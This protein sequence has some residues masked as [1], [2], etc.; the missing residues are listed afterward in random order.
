[1]SPASAGAGTYQLTY[2]LDNDPCNDA[3]TIDIVV[4]NSATV[5]TQ[6]ELL[7]IDSAPITLTVNPT[8]GTWSGDGIT[9]PNAGTFDP[10]IA[11]VGTHQPTYSFTDVN[12]CGVVASPTITV[13]GLPVLLAPDTLDVCQTNDDLSLPDL[14]NVTASPGGGNFSWMG[15][16]TQPNGIFNSGAAGLGEGFYSIR[17]TSTRN[18]CV[19]TDSLIVAV[20]IPAPLTLD[21]PAEICIAEGT[22]T[23]NS[24]LAGG[25]WTGPNIDPTTGEIDLVGA[26]GEVT[27]VQVNIASAGESEFVNEREELRAKDRAGALN[28][29]EAQRLAEVEAL[30][31]QYNAE[32]LARQS[33]LV[34]EVRAVVDNYRDAA[35]IFVGG[36]P[37]IAADMVSF[38][39]SDLQLFGS[40]ILGVMVLVLALI[41]RKPK[42][43]LIPLLSCSLSVAYTLGILG[44]LDW[45]MTVISSNVVAVL[46]IVAL[47]IAIHLV[48]RYRE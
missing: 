32:S 48:V 43:V 20:T 8:G 5:T 26:G 38:V 15:P 40:A 37:M 22:L 33:A 31:K 44:F 1:F 17:F 34:T 23:L 21:G 9:D 18:D 19:V 39:R 14:S 30:V 24:N 3:A 11:G 45:R 46:L 47:A 41:F 2:S 16:G 29:D 25:R 36:V 4:V 10:V 28:P 6:D 35:R 7:C 27:A 12:G 42:W 13:E